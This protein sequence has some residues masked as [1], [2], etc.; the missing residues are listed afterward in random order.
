M[1]HSLQM[2]EKILLELGVSSFMVDHVA[3][4]CKGPAAEFAGIRL[5]TSVGPDVM[6]KTC[7]L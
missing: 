6:S 2:F 7:S 4:S 1:N 5:L 3:F